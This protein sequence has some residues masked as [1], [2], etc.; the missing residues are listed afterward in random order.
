MKNLNINS[1]L[2]KSSVLPLSI[3]NVFI[4]SLIFLSDFKFK[5]III[6]IGV[7]ISQALVIYSSCYNTKKQDSL[8]EMVTKISTANLKELPEYQGKDPISKM[9]NSLSTASKNL[10]FIIDETKKG[11]L[12]VHSFS[13]ELLDTI[14]ILSSNVKD[15]DS[16][17]H[18]M[19]DGATSLSSF[20]QEIS[21]T[22]GELENAI[23]VLSSES[24][25]GRNYSNKIQER[26][27]NVQELA[28]SSY[29]LANTILV[30]KKDKIN[31]SIEKAT[32]VSQIKLLLDTIVDI[33]DKTN[34]LS[35]NAS[36]EAARAGEYGKGFSVVAQEIR[37]L[38][39]NSSDSVKNIYS[40]VEDVQLA[41]NDLSENATDILE[42]IDNQVKPD[43]QKLVEV[44]E[45]YQEDSKYIHNFSKNIAES[46]ELMKNS[47][48]ETSA[49]MQQISATS[50]QFASGAEENANNVS[51]ISDSFRDIV[52]KTETQT[53]RIYKISNLLSKIK[54][55][56]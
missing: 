24:E 4:L 47:I 3:I 5:T 37:K 25:E 31:K 9:T 39:E 28:T 38:A 56:L 54:T 23:V 32:V 49:S 35:L 42:F 22:T 34:L 33:T 43:Y 21:A 11:V 53:T 44:G 7:L 15:I 2:L 41:F 8:K 40:V 52:D 27:T 55:T 19:A 46:T 51:N 16:I 48:L 6:L 45:L 1:Y 14:K 30:E 26:A 18:E 20:T 10:R 13:N 29:N 50:Q 36:I 12:D 17:T